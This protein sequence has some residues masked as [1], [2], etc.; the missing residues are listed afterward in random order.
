[1]RRSLLVLALPLLILSACVDGASGGG[2]DGAAGQTGALLRVDTAGFTDVVG[3]HFSIDRVACDAAEAFHPLRIEADVDL[4]DMALPGDF[5]LRA[6][7]FDE[8]SDALAA[9]LFV[10]LPPGC[11]EVAAYPARDFPASGWLPSL[12]CAPAPAAAAAVEDGATA[13]L[14]LISQCAGDEG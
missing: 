9:D 13:E 10:S 14:L 1:M 12:D 4:L 7:S 11:Y 3:F 2:R 5:E 8:E 6:H